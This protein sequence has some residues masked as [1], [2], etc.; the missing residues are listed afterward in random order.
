MD[1]PNERG[2]SYPGFNKRQIKIYQD[3]HNL[4]GQ[5]SAA[6]YK[7]ACRIINM[8][9][10]LESTTHIVAHLFREIESS[11][12]DV[13]EPISNKNISIKTKENKNGKDKQ[14]TEILSILKS[15]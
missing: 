13:L 11:L 8:D 10:P 15:L 2:F 3:L 14:R 5:G 1:E 7:D 9:P 4:I 12:R 6:F